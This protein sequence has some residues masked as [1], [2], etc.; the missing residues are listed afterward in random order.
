MNSVGMKVKL[1]AD[2]NVLCL[3]GNVNEFLAEK[4]RN[5]I[6]I[7]YSTSNEFS[8]VMIVY[9]EEDER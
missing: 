2:R 1:F 6:N 4:E 3:E 5:I 7:K 9:S 8:E